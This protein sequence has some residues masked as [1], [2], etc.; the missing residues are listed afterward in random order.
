MKKRTIII[1][2]SETVVGAFK[3]E[4]YSVVFESRKSYGHSQD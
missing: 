2:L 1:L 3:E 4:L